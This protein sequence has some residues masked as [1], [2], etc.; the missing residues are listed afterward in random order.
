M[1][2]GASRY[3]FDRL[4]VHGT[5]PFI[6]R[7][8][9]GTAGWG[10]GGRRRTPCV[11]IWSLVTPLEKRNTSGHRLGCSAQVSAPPSLPWGRR[12]F[13]LTKAARLSAILLVHG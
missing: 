4:F 12:L 8:T 11:A 3:T 9:R 2:V 7:S 13:S 1:A 5:E 10:W 6:D